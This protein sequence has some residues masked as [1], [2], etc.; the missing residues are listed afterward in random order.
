MKKRKYENAGMKIPSK[1]LFTVF[2]KNN[3]LQLQS[4]IQ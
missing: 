1:S 4:T 2:I 3:Y